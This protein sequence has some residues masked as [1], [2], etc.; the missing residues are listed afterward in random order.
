MPSEGNSRGLLSTKH[1]SPTP[2]LV[3]HIGL[4]WRTEGEGEV[5]SPG[6][7]LTE[8]ERHEIKGTEIL[9]LLLS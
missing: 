7:P 4:D 1:V 3:S 9:P 6:N 5:D 2:V 8:L